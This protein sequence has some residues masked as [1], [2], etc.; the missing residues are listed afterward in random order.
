M[1]I[2]SANR[3]PTLSKQTIKA[4]VKLDAYTQCTLDSTFVHRLIVGY[5]VSP[6]L[7]HNVSIIIKSCVKSTG[8]KRHEVPV[9]SEPITVIHMDEDVVVVNKPAS[10]PKQH[11]NGF[12]IRVN[13][14]KTS[15]ST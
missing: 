3:K 15:K 10:I 9:T 13:S 2:V 12:N 11:V 14:N 5:Y 6:S 1:Q 7:V 8:V 4:I